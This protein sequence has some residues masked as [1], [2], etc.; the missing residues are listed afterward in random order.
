[1]NNQ[2]NNILLSADNLNWSVRG[3]S[4]LK[5]LTFC[6]NRGDFI[7]IIG[8]NG[9]GK[10]SLLRCLYHKISPSSGTIHFEDRPLQQLSR[11]QI[12]QKI[13]VVLQEPPTDFDISVLDVIRMGLIP[14]KSLL[15]FDTDEDQQ[16][17]LA[18]AEKVDLSNHLSQSF[19][20][21]SGGEKQRAII[22]RAILQNPQ[23]LLMDEP[24]NHLDIRHQIDVLKLAG[25]MNITVLVSI[26]DLNL[27]ATFCNRLIMLDE[28]VIVADGTP[29]QVLTQELLHRVFGIHAELDRH[30]FSNK[31]RITFDLNDHD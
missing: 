22:A 21:L 23:L 8:P 30:P 10:T 24:T 19:N 3:R 26:H 14:N 29:E 2:D 12:A 15:S 31:V 6:I 4:I 11:Q 28:G 17:I 20:S 5:N 1:M 13:A 27:A 16:A 25:S 7:G 18:A 9:A